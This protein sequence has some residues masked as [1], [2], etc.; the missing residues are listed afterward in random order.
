MADAYFPA[1]AGWDVPR[2]QAASFPAPMAGAGA[3]LVE[4]HA[5]L[6]SCLWYIGAQQDDW[7]VGFGPMVLYRRL[8]DGTT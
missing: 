2:A 3:E 1:D 7:W 8:W 4:C 6:G 5:S